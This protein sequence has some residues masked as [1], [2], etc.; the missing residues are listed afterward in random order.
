MEKNP[1]TTTTTG[2]SLDFMQYAPSKVG[3]K[4]RHQEDIYTA[5]G[6]F[7]R[8]GVQYETLVDAIANNEPGSG[9]VVCVLETGG[10]CDAESCYKV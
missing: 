3:D 10:W 1:T 8:S 6:F 9:I 5:N 4:F 7:G 2:T